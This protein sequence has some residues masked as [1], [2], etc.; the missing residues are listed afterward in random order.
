MR[1]HEKVR[2]LN[3]KEAAKARKSIQTAEQPVER[4]S[5]NP[6]GGPRPR[7]EGDGPILAAG[8]TVLQ[9]VLQALPSLWIE[10][11]AVTGGR[12]RSLGEGAPIVLEVA[13]H[14]R[15]VDRR[16]VDARQTGLPHQACQT[17]WRAKG[18]ALVFG[19]IQRARVEGRC[20]SPEGMH[21]LNAT[22]RIVPDVE[23]DRSTDPSY[24]LHL[25]ESLLLVGH[26]VQHQRRGDDVPGCLL[27][28]QSL[29]V[30][31]LEIGA[32]FR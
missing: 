21:E 22:A 25:P 27:Q 13:K 32:P 29:G 5:T 16:A 24:P 10:T 28:R 20:G 4:S 31:H 3:T 30:P 6:F 7:L 9:S 1:V 23:A 17:I 26:E 2:D 19:E 18:K 11:G 8:E 12:P 15:H 14:G